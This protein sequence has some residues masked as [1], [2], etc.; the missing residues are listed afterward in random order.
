VFEI[1][2]LYP[3]SADSLA[4]MERY[5]VLDTAGNP[6]EEPDVEAWSQWFAQANRHVARTIVS[7]E[8]T[9]LSTFSGVHDAAPA[10]ATPRLFESRVFGGV[11]DGEVV[12]Q[13]TRADATRRHDELSAW[14][15]IGNAPDL[16]ITDADIT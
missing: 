4:E 16:G 3:V 14:C 8:V 15:R 2:H 13:S 5:F 10:D 1:V 12:T 11:L 7:P 9:V 6:V